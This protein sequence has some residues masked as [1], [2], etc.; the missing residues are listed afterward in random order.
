LLDYAF[1]AEQLD[2]VQYQERITRLDEI[3]SHGLFE[4]NA[5]PI[6]PVGWELESHRIDNTPLWDL[7]KQLKFL[8]TPEQRRKPVRGTEIMKQI[9]T[10]PLVNVNLLDYLID[11]MN[12]GERAIPNEW[13]YDIQGQ[14]R[15][16]FFCGTIFTSEGGLL[17]RC[18]YWNA[19][20]WT[21]SFCWLD[22]FWNASYNILLFNQL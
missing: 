2:S 14:T 9:R 6:V 11:Q 7:N 4:P 1:Q 13:K 5:T 20:R 10:L 18:L 16:I 17:V 8:V 15:Y 22:S 12:A 21:P 19:Y 3:R